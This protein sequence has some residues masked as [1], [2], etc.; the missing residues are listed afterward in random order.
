MGSPVL[1]SQERLGLF[2]KPFELKKFRTMD[3][4]RDEQG[5]VLTDD[6]RLTR[7]G[8]WLR[9]TSLDELPELWNIARGEMCFVG[10][11]P[12]PTSY[13]DRYSK[14]EFR[15]HAVRP[16]LTGWAQVNGRNELEW[17][18]RLA[19]DVWY[20]DHQSLRLDAR[21]TF[22]TLREVLAQRGISSEGSVTM[23]ELRPF[24][25]RNGQHE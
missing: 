7:L 5:T 15:R 10:P 18:D 1:F 19:M 16:G 9:H 20:V 8:V 2:G 12:L 4:E 17:N 3:E 21:I 24:E 11:R 6:C 23:E 14:E 22:M 13:R 25:E